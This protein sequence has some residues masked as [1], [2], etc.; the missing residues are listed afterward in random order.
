MAEL[1]PDCWKLCHVKDSPKSL[2][3]VGLRK[4]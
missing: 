4:R 1:L 3:I 2:T